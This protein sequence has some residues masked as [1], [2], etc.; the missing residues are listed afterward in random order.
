MGR[1]RKYNTEEERKAA[2]RERAR[3]RRLKKKFELLDM[4]LDVLPNSHMQVPHDVRAE[5]HN[6]VYGPSVD[7]YTKRSKVTRNKFIK[8]KKQ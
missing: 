7:L 6:I 1:P 5:A 2:A 4:D 3:V 8:A